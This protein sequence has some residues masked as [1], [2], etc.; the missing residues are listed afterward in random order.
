M[1]PIP[2]KV[3]QLLSYSITQFLSRPLHLELCY[4]LKVYF[5]SEGFISEFLSFYQLSAE[6]SPDHHEF[7]L[8]FL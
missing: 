1:G 5:L 3:T 7:R 2:Q 6:I 8:Q 4:K